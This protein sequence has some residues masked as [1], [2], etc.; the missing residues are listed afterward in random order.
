VNKGTAVGERPDCGEYG[1]DSERNRELEEEVRQ[2][3]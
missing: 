2:G 3:A 1:C